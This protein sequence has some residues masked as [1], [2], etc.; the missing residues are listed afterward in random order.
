MDTTRKGCLLNVLLFGFGAILG[1]GL[2]AVAAVLLFL[3]S[4]TTVDTNEGS[5]NVYVK[6]RTRLIG[7]TEHEVWLGQTEDYGHVV[8]IPDGWG[9]APE[10]VRTEEGVELRFG[11]GGG[12]EGEGGGTSGIGGGRIFVPKEAYTGG[13]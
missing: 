9:T 7:G 2:T 12:G 5:P 13:R 4:S 11:G 10:V 8:P 1:T 6:E 3:P